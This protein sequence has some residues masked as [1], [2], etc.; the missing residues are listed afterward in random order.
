MGMDHKSLFIERPEGRLR[1]IV[2]GEA[3]PPVLLLSG[4]GLDNALLSW[5]HLIPTLAPTHRVFALDWPKQGESRPWRGR[6]DH[7]A[8]M[9]LID[10]LFAHFGLETASLVGLSQGGALALAYAIERPERVARLVAIA[11]GGT[12]RFAPGMHQLLWLTAKLSW[13]VHVISTLLLRN[14]T[15]AEWSCRALFPTPPP[16]FEDV[17][18]DVLA[19][20]R[21]N[22]AGAS[23]WQNASIGFLKMRVDLSPELHR[24]ACPTLFIQ[25]DKDPA[26]NP[27]FTREAAGRVPGARLVMLEGHG[28]WP[29]RQSP[30]R[31]NALIAEFLGNTG[32]R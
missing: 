22:G 16:D 6:A 11:P 17:V 4:A 31:V 15:L 14:R 7:A 2:A 27:K 29:S 18:E 23:D 8:L 13:P 26:V 21:R 9:G 20:A 30:E 5:K 1:V 12:L 3:G 32:A 19:E 28:H 24:I 10:A 25:G